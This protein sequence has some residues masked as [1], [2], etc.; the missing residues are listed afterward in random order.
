[1]FSHSLYLNVH[2]F[3]VFLTIASLMGLATSRILSKEPLPA[4]LRIALAAGHGI[5]VFLI[6]LGGFGLLARLGIHSD[7]PLW[8]KLKL[9]LW[10]L[11]AV[12]IVAVKRLPVVAKAAWIILPTLAA[13]AAWLAIYRPE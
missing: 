9:A 6:L 10:G 5:G 11:F 4:L 3:G 2:L 8:V 1:M 7:W 12:L 13:V